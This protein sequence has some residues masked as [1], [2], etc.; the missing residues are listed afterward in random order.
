M[1]F[2]IGLGIDMSKFKVVALILYVTFVQACAVNSERSD[3]S[4]QSRAYVSSFYLEYMS[5]TEGD[6]SFRRTKFHGQ[7]EEIYLVIDRN[8]ETIILREAVGESIV[9]QAYEM[10]SNNP[11]MS[12]SNF[13]DGIKT[14]TITIGKEQYGN[15]KKIITKI[16]I[17]TLIDRIEKQEGSYGIE[18]VA[19]GESYEYSMSNSLGY[20]LSLENNSDS[21]VI[22]AFMELR[23]SILM[24]ENSR[25]TAD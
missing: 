23:R 12:Y 5:L 14:R 8:N 7:T 16:D 21:K 18:V 10:L 15:Y 24:E 20:I 11:S 9:I 6:I 1:P 3:I 25:A 17:A 2:D 22:Q 19:D 4:E 13:K